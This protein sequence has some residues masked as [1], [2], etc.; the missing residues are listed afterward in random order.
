MPAII[1]LIIIFG[2]AFGG[3]TF[4]LIKTVI[5]PKR[6]ATLLEYYRQSKYSAAI[7]MARQIIAKEPRNSEAHYL[8]G[9]SYLGDAKP[10]LALMELKTVNQIGKFGG[11][12]PEVDFRKSIAALFSRYGQVEEA[13]KEYLLLMKLEPMQADH[14]FH[15][16]ELFEERNKTEKA[17][18]FYRKTIEVEPRHSNAHYKLGYLL[19]RSKKPVEAK[20]ELET[21]I[22]LRPDNYTAHFY[23]GRLMKE[24]HDYV[25]ALHCFE[26][27]QRD[28][29]MKVK[30]LVERGSCYMSMNNFDKAVS[31]LERSIKLSK[32][33]AATESL[34]ARYFLALCYE[35]MR[36][37]DHAVEQWEKIYAKKPQ[38]R[39][40]AEKLSQYQ[41]LRTD[42][43]LKD[44]LTVSTQEFHELCKAACTQMG[45]RVRD[46]SEIPN[47][48][49]IIAVDDDTRWRNTRKMPRLLHFLRVPEMIPESSVRSFSELMK[50]IS[51]QRGIMVSSSNFSRVAMDFVES[52]PIDLI[53]KDK[54]QQLL[55]GVEMP[56][57]SAK[58]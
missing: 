39:D 25:A 7:R 34:F 51:V 58:R 28:P 15:S 12:C 31:E 49:Q 22:K 11:I 36:D 44:Y 55:K 54:L 35:K 24:G 17:L 43:R 23:L 3:I 4:F 16:A 56:A 46:L 37:I 18:D 14:Y 2:T 50:K 45:L 38:F 29:D 5:A 57:A 9:L 26:K 42:D 27:A 19:Y 53:D 47:G 1:I 40:V 33:E 21:A 30:A 32:D 8:L 10:E 20:A 13:L 6:V 48:C 52:R 41:D